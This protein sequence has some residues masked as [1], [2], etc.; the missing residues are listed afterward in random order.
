MTQT[1]NASAGTHGP[2]RMSGMDYLCI[3]CATTFKLDTGRDYLCFPL[4]CPACEIKMIDAIGLAFD[5][6]FA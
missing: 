6:M 2:T 3:T 4:H 1:M 5:A